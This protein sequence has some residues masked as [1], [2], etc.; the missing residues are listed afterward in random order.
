MVKAFNFKQE[1]VA[2]FDYGVAR[3]RDTSGALDGLYQEY[4]A[5]RQQ[6]GADDERLVNHMT[7][8][9]SRTTATTCGAAFAT[10]TIRSLAAG[11]GV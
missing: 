10:S 11:N 9:A 6:D 1:L 4:V 8:Y 5:E 3:Q 7:V 2:A